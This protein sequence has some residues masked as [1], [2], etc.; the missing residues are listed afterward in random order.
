MSRGV[1]LVP[2]DQT[3][4][5]GKYR[6]W[7]S[8]EE[9]GWSEGR[10]RP[11]KHIGGILIYIHIMNYIAQIEVQYVFS[12]NTKFPINTGINIVAGVCVGGEAMG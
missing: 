6:E 2:A 8:G 7:K 1:A 3:S 9:F 12:F 4:V 5:S 10:T 11:G